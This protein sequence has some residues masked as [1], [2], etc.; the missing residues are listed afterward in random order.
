M[1]ANYCRYRPKVHKS[2]NLPIRRTPANIPLAYRSSP[3][4]E[5]VFSAAMVQKIPATYK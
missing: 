5:S 4:L 3:E 2:L 1:G